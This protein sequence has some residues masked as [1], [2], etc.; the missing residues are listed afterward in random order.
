MRASKSVSLGPALL[1]ILAATLLAPPATAHAQ[2]P[3]RVLQQMPRD[4]ARPTDVITITF[5]RP[6]AGTLEHTIDLSRFV[7]IEPA[8]R[9]RI[10]WRDPSTIRIVPLDP[11]EPAHRYRITIGTGFDALDGS[12]LAAPERFTL[13]VRG[14]ALIGS[15][16]A[17]DARSTA[18]L[19]PTGRLLLSF[20]ST[21]ADSILRQ[22]VRVTTLAGE[23]CAAA[24]TIG[25]RVVGHRAL[26][27]DDSWSLHPYPYY[28][29]PN[30]FQRVVELMPEERLPEECMGD[31]TLPTLD[32]LDATEVRFRVLT[33]KPFGLESLKC[34]AECPVAKGVTLSFDAPVAPMELWKSVHFEPA[35]AFAPTL[36]KLPT[37]QWNV[38]ATL[39]V[40]STYRV[41][42]D[43]SLR[44]IYGRAI[45]FGFARTIVIGD[46]EPDFGYRTGA[47][48]LSADLVPTVKL[49]HVNVDSVALLLMPVSERDRVPYLL[50]RTKW[51]DE[52]RGQLRDTIVRVIALHAPFNEE[53]VTDVPLPELGSRFIGRLVVLQ[54][55]LIK[56][57]VSLDSVATL[58]S[59]KKLAAK[60][61]PKST[62]AKITIVGV[63]DDFAKV[64]GIAHPTPRALL[65]ATDLMAHARSNSSGAFVWVTSARTGQPVPAARVALL[66]TSGAAIASAV[67]DDR[68]IAILKVQHPDVPLSDPSDFD[69]YYGDVSSAHFLDVRRGRD[70]SLTSLQQFWYQ[71]PSSP[72]LPDATLDGESLDHGRAS[73]ALVFA[74]RGIYR[75]GEQ[76]N[77]GAVVREGILGQLHS[78]PADD[79]AR[80]IF[81]RNATDGARVSVRDTVIRLSRFGTVAHAFQLGAQAEFGSYHLDL[82][83]MRNGRWQAAGGTLLRIA[84]YRAPEFLVDAHADSLPRLRGDSI[85]MHV[86]AKYL[87]GAPMGRVAVRWSAQFNALDPWAIRIPGVARE[88]VIG[89]QRNWWSPRTIRGAPSL[90]GVDTLDAAGTARLS[91]STD[92]VAPGRGANANIEVSVVD[93][94][95]QTVT[96]TATVLVHPASFY[97]ALRDSAGSMWWPLHA[98]HRVQL[99]GVRPDGRKVRGVKVRIAIVA[100]RWSAT[101][102]DDIGG[103]ASEW[104]ADTVRVDTLVTADSL[105]AIAMPTMP[106]GPVEIIATAVDERGRE[107]RTTMAR[108]LFD[109]GGI[110][111]G[112]PLALPVHMQTDH[113]KPGE[114]AVVSFT[115]P[116]RSADAWVTVER[117]GVLSERLLRNVH[118]TVTV[119][120]PVTERE[121]PNAFVS[122]FLVR[123]GIFGSADSASQRMRIGYAALRVDDR[124]KR[125]TVQ[126]RPLRADYAPGDSAT[127]ELSVKDSRSR[128]AVSEA[129]MWAADEGVLALTGYTTPDPMRRMYAPTRDEIQ[130]S[131]TLFSIRVGI[132]PWL[133]RVA[134]R[135]D[136]R[137]YDSLLSAVNGGFAV[138]AAPPPTGSAILR[139]DFR[140]TAFFRGGLRTDTNGVARITVKLPDNITTFRLMAVA[141]SAGDQYGSAEAPLLVTKPLVLRP[142]LPRFIRANDSVFAGAV[143]N[144]RDRR[145]HALDVEASGSGVTLLGEART[146]TMLDSSGTEVRFAWRGLVGDSARFRISASDGNH[147]DGVSIA[148]PIKPDRVPRSRTQSGM[149]TDSAVVHFRLSRDLDPV[150]SR[151]TI[152]TGTSPV[153]TLR[154][155]RAFLLASQYSCTDQLTSVG[156]MYVSLLAAE[157]SG[158]KV[159]GDTVL[160]R[161]ELQRIADE[162]ARRE[163]VKVYSDCWIPF[164]I[165]SPVRADANLLLLDLRDIGVRVDTALVKRLAV[166]FTHVLDSLPLFPD[167]TYGRRDERRLRIA[168]HLQGRVGAV[169]FLQRIGIPRARDLRQLRDNAAR[170]TWEDRAWL[171]GILEQA[172]EHASALGL[173]NQLWSTL[174]QAGNRVEVPDSLLLSVG[175]PSHIRP[176]ARLLNATLAI[177]PD[178]PRLGALVERLTTRT[179]AERDEWWNTQDHVNATVALARFAQL[180]HGSDARLSVGFGSGA[181]PG[182]R[183][184]ITFE[185]GA[186]AARDT[187]MILDGLTQIIGDS[188]EVTVRLNTSGGAQFYAVTIDEVT[189]ERP[190]RPDISGLSVERWYERYDDGRTVT[191]VREGDLVRVRLRVTA[192]AS[193]EF[194]TLEDVLPA[195]LEAVDLTLRTSGTLG[196]FSSNETMA[197]ARRRDA[198]AGATPDDELYGSWYGGWWSPWGQTDQHDDRTVFF[199]RKLWRGSFTVSYVA[200][201]TTA[202]RFVRPQAHAEEM[203]NPALSGRSE[204]GW[205]VVRVGEGASVLRP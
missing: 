5:D 172:G 75:P 90:H 116:W 15:D 132:P 85:T 178:H 76:V 180:H 107:A 142:A 40:R 167:T 176:V 205:F 111:G 110:A 4:I 115:S 101:P 155:A 137:L 34:Q 201:A 38:A 133:W 74:D 179:R 140:T 150:K 91:I 52:S 135:I 156:R 122:V 139:S 78:P 3:L 129:T 65:Q 200:R 113:L 104:H 82:S 28:G 55:K 50:G 163:R 169:A 173:L 143:I 13:V 88:W 138:G 99:M 9:A 72:P 1:A 11:L 195:G 80:L 123:R 26:R 183:P 171:A 127:F 77:V 193:R 136:R 177:T 14:P 93:I 7:R 103:A 119:R 53:R 29:H 105:L 70:R 61:P 170:L 109:R 168:D 198:E 25:Y 89:E 95:R 149:V 23:R 51:P 100:Y 60:P 126:I 158:V 182:A 63:A 35:A 153:P 10:E 194:V 185:P 196:P 20:S 187:S 17:L 87:F 154:I 161:R 33:A 203:Y 79:S 8:V 102:R 124:S 58:K 84:D 27:D 152:R 43:S 146:R 46:R 41:T 160:A 120:L 184:A 68:G 190:T 147:T 45:T 49:R 48:F 192:S 71:S 83:L 67:T 197:N 114:N 97:L 121:V 6:V 24:R 57:A 16:P 12:R 44:D 2:E 174:A 125:L 30:E 69:D 42:V 47:Q 19:D 21:V 144:A 81:S 151:L 145:P 39:A 86:S 186:G 181:E 18:R 31:L 62:A 148:L 96:A 37:S 175:F 94:N 108:Y 130:L 112:T 118:G 106:E 32:S 59:A 141:V 134:Q 166:E 199:A 64:A 189:R 162:L 157:R 54:A 56:S 98:S 22:T 73:R 66:N 131:S 191:E 128:G 164:W 159:I 204:G 202:G 165:G 188:A 92:S 36:P 117:E